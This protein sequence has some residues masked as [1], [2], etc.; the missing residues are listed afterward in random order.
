M[1]S[2]LSFV[3]EWVTLLCWRTGDRNNSPE[4][5][6]GLKPKPYFCI[7][8]VSLS[9]SH[10]SLPCLSFLCGVRGRSDSYVNTLQYIPHEWRGIKLKSQNPS[11]YQSILLQ[12]VSEGSSSM[13]PP[14]HSWLVNYR[15]HWKAKV[16]TQMIIFL[17]SIFRLQSSHKYFSSFS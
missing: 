15:T 9:A 12:G 4:K 1:G 2:T 6:Q 10:S 13:S 5:T 16:G 14:P 17:K 3:R 11:N 8:I 7:N